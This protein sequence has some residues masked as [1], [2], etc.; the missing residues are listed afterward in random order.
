MSVT[1]TTSCSQV[2]TR[3]E[4]PPTFYM[5]GLLTGRVHT[6]HGW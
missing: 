3:E 6:H 4:I 5:H 2:I 1:K